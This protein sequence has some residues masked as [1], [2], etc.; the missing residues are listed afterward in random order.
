MAHFLVL[1]ASNAV[2]VVLY[3][4]MQA[5]LVGTLQPAIVPLAAGLAVWSAM[6]F[7]ILLPPVE[8]RFASDQRLGWLIGSQLSLVYAVMRGAPL[9]RL[10]GG[11]SEYVIVAVLVM[12]VIV[13]SQIVVCAVFT[14]EERD[15]WT[16]R[17]RRRAAKIPDAPTN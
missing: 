16:L 2:S 3:E 10:P 4:I 8:R 7:V 13:L 6:V 15:G 1:L 11:H 14:R 9:W 17:A 12:P 5:I